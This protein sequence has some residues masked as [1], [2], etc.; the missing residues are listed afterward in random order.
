[1]H[2]LDH[3]GRETST[4]E[5]NKINNDN[6][7][8][9][10]ITVKPGASLPILTKRTYA[11]W[12]I[13]LRSVAAS[14]G[15]WDHILHDYAPASATMS[16]KM[17]EDDKVKRYRAL[18]LLVIAVHPDVLEEINGDITEMSPHMLFSELTRLT[19]IDSREQR[20]EYLRE[21]AENTPMLNKDTIERYI[22]KHRTIRTDMIRA[23]VDDAENENLTVRYMI[24]GIKNHPIYGDHWDNFVLDEPE[25]IDEFEARLRM[26]NNNP[27]HGMPHCELHGPGS[28]ITAQCRTLR[29]QRRIQEPGQL[30]VPTHTRN[31]VTPINPPRRRIANKTANLENHAPPIPAENSENNPQRKPNASLLHAQYTSLLLS[32]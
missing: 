28:H 17:V 5:V 11:V 25:T 10:L 13:S 2:R 27:T 32:E 29:R 31:M 24:H 9:V 14:E 18:H 7:M 8:P 26:I 12:Y 23:N 22:E 4:Y 6:T 1:M 20:R 15:I 3:S 19:R 21:K 30:T 16:R